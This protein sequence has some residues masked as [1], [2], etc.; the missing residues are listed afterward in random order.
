MTNALTT[1]TPAAMPGVRKAAVLLITLG[2]EASVELARHFKEKELQKIG[3]EIARMGAIRPEEAEG[4]LHEFYSLLE[5]G[6]TPRG[7]TQFAEK[8]LVG[9]LGAAPAQ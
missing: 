1:V 4:V 8:L 9:A 3:E 5:N 2:D 7:G 6:P